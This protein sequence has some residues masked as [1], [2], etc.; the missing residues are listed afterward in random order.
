M[1]T[2]LRTPSEHPLR[3]HEKKPFIVIENWWVCLVRRF[4]FLSLKRLA[5]IS[6]VR[7]MDRSC[8]KHCPVEWRKNCDDNQLSRH[9]ARAKRLQLWM[10]KITTL[11]YPEFFLTSTPS[12]LH[13][14]CALSFQVCARVSHYF[15]DAPDIALRNS[16]LGLTRERSGSIII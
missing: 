12:P 1:I 14:R 2:Y 9:D 13:F 3:C 7:H 4:S 15:D 5:A 8:K 10:C 6:L 11:I 16:G